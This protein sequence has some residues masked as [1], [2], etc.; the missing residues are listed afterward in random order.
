MN[1]N[2]GFSWAIYGFLGKRLKVN[3]ST[4]QLKCWGLLRV[5]PERRFFTPPSKA[6]LG[7]AEWV[8]F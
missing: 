7:A 2:L 1:P 5:D 8:N 6:G 4:P 3:P